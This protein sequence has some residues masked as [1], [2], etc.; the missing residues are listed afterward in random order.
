MVP[1]LP[2]LA[3]CVRFPDDLCAGAGCRSSSFGADAALDAATGTGPFSPPGTDDEAHSVHVAP[4]GSDETGDGTPAFPYRSIGASLT[5]TTDILWAVRICSGKYAETISVASSDRVVMLTGGY[6]CPASGAPWS[7]LA[8]ATVVRSAGPHRVTAAGAIFRNL[9]LEGSDGTALSRSTTA[10]EVATRGRAILVD[11]HVRSGL[12]GEGF[13]GFHAPDD[14][15]P[16]AQGGSPSG[17]SGGP[18]ITTI[19]ANGS[20]STGGGGGSSDGDPMGETGRPVPI[21]TAAGSN[22]G[23]AGSYT[24]RL[25]FCTYGTAGRDANPTAA[26]VAGPPGLDATTFQAGA[27]V[28]GLDG[29]P[30][31][32]GGG[33][34]TASQETGAPSG[35]SGGCGGRGGDGGGGGGSSIAIVVRQG[36][37]ALFSTR[38]DVAPGGTGGNGGNGAPGAAGGLGIAAPAVGAGNA[39]PCGSGNGGHGAGGGGGSGGEG[40]SALGILA[41]RGTEVHID[42]SS[43]TTDRDEDPSVTLGAA[44]A[45]GS[46][47]ARGIGRAG[48]GAGAGAGA[49]AADGKTGARQAVRVLHD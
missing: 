47:G 5:H 36:V 46:G 27:G 37:L 26:Q 13:S 7:A 10:L 43:V 45:G 48:A 49:P 41:F 3:A 30:G 28:R 2:V 19:C 4:S 8:G 25:V 12:G 17:P 21:D 32:G 15:R 44:G 20:S 42:G 31:Q 9:T 29:A 33:G 18:E 23:R 22:G 11:A 35:A 40:G 6:S 39:G 34:G 1:L 24:P 38:V 16:G 14:A